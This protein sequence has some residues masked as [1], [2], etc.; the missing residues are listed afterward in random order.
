MKQGYVEYTDLIKGIDM[1]FDKGYRV[2]FKDG[3]LRALNIVSKEVEKQIINF[4]T[5][6]E[7]SK[8]KEVEERMWEDGEN[9]ES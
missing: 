8:N 1:S 7:N 2:G 5:M 3:Y 6:N 4:N 9:I